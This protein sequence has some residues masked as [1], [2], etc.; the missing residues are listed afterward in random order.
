[1]LVAIAI[2]VGNCVLVSG[3]IQ[4][5]L[6]EVQGFGVSGY[7][8][9][10]FTLMLDLGACSQNGFDSIEMPGRGSGFQSNSH[11]SS[12]MLCI[13][14]DWESNSLHNY[15]VGRGGVNIYLAINLKP[16][17][18]CATLLVRRFCFASM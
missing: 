7:V 18:I 15:S 17:W 8:I 1:M 2:L 4:R 6:V 12:M 14:I 9:N 11:F 10:D 5:V 13:G 3:R 16:R